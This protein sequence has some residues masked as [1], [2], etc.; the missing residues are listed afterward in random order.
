MKLVHEFALISPISAYWAPTSIQ[1]QAYRHLQAYLN[2]TY[3]HTDT[4]TQTHTQN[5]LRGLEA[6]SFKTQEGPPAGSLS[7]V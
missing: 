4:S 1:T 3:K 6:A 5:H 7:H 2:N